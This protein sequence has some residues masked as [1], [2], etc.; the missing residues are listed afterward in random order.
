MKLKQIFSIL[1]FILLSTSKIFAASIVTCNGQSQLHSISLGG[2]VYGGT[3]TWLSVN[4]SNLHHTYNVNYG[5]DGPYYGQ[6]GPSSLRRWYDEWEYR[7]VL[8]A[9]ER[10][11]EAIEDTLYFGL[12][13]RVIFNGT[14]DGG[15]K[16]NGYYELLVQKGGFGFEDGGVPLNFYSVVNVDD[17]DVLNIRTAPNA[18]TRK[19]GEIPSYGYGVIGLSNEPVNGWVFVNYKGIEGWVSQRY[20]GYGSNRTDNEFIGA[21]ECVDSY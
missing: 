15:V 5:P 3:P 13:F 20:L 1:M 17:G 16:F 18:Q 9:G 2:A 8:T 12:E 19:L 4:M 11:I 14:V 21:I 6:D 10:Y 7:E